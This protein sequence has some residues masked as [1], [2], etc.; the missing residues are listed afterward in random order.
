MEKMNTKSEIIE[1]AL[2]FM[3]SAEMIEHMRSGDWLYLYDVI[4][5]IMTS[6]ASFEEKIASM[7]SGLGLQIVLIG[8]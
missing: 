2:Q 6:R 7:Q 1:I 4:N 8:K 5:T 3:E